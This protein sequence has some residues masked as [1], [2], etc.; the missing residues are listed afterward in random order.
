MSGFIKIQMKKQSD[1]KKNYYIKRIF[2]IFILSWSLLFSS[3]GY[4][5]TSTYKEH[6]NS[7]TG[8][9]ACTLK[10][11]NEI[12]SDNDT[13]GTS[14]QLDCQES[15]IDVVK[16][17]FYDSE[18]RMLTKSIE[19]ACSL[20]F[21]KVD[22]LPSG[23]NYIVVVMAED[24]SG[25]ILLRGEYKDFSI[26]TG[27]I[28]SPPGGEIQMDKFADFTNSIGM[29]F[30]LIQPGTF[31]M[32]TPFG[33]ISWVGDETP[34]EVTLTKSFYIQTTEVTQGQWEA[35]MG[36]NPS[37]NSSCGRNCPVETIT[38]EDVQTYITAL[39]NLGEG[40]YRLPTEA[41]WEYAA[42]AGSTTAYANG[43]NS[44]VF[45]EFDTNLNSIGWYCYNEPTN[46]KPVAQKD[47]N[48]WGLYDMHGNVGEFVQDWYGEYPSEPVTD[49]TGPPSGEQIISRGGD[50]SDDGIYCRSGARPVWYPHFPAFGGNG[51]RLVREP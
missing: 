38:W 15:G 12:S 41:E 4:E 47:S 22:N 32:G 28:T 14:R 2:C 6:N 18:Y 39:N 37:S 1:H 40:V 34:H 36:S 3:C 29:T 13:S 20:H 9:F 17:T 10:W 11:P 42:R 23:H 19:F 30:N 25:T 7:A 33:V 24:V 46:S 27:E 43:G 26:V 35:L 44:N 50:S 16:F 45:C 51:L 21:G 8:S 49:P 48:A 31:T 5:D